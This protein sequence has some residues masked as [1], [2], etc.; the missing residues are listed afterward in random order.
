MAFKEFKKIIEGRKEEEL[1]AEWDDF[2]RW[3]SYEVA[4][5]YWNEV[6]ERIT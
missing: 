1:F 3:E 2:I 6:E 4:L 5:R